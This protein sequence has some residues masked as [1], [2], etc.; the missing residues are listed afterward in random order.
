M[1]LVLIQYCRGY[2]K[3]AVTSPEPMSGGNTCRHPDTA[4]IETTLYANRREK[5]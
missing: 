1:A 5:I 4:Q 2:Q 3:S